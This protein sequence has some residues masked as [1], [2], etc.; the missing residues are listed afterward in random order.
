MGFE[1]RGNMSGGGAEDGGNDEGSME[2]TG[3][4]VGAKLHARVKV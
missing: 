1:R 2:I 4:K 3:G